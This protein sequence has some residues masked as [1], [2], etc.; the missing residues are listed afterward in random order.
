MVTESVRSTVLSRL[1][2][3]RSMQRVASPAL[4]IGLGSTAC[5]IS[6]HLEDA[7]I[8]WSA[9]DR[10]S[11]GFLYLDTRE[12]TRDEITRSSRFIGLTLPHFSNLR[13]LRPWITECVPELRHLSLSREGALGML[14]NAGVAA[15]YNYASMRGH[16][17][18]LIGE[19]CPYYEGKT[20]LRVHVIAFLGGGTIG[21]LPVLLAAL[22]EARGTA[23]N[24]STVL[25]LLMPQRGMSRDPDN[26]Y[27]LQLRNA[28][29]T[30][31]FLRAATGV[32]AGREQHTGRD[33]YQITV[34]P[35]KTVQAVGP[36][37]D[38]AI[39]HRS[40]K[41]SIPAQK[42]HVARILENLVT[43]AW[44][45]GSDLWAR[46]HET[47]REANNKV[48]AR[49]GSISSKEVSLL[50]GFFTSP[51]RHSFSSMAAAPLRISSN[52]SPNSSPNFMLLEIRERK[53]LS[54]ATVSRIFSAMA[55][56][57]SSSRSLRATRP[58]PKTRAPFSETR[59]VSATSRT[60]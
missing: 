24:F 26:S 50:D 36:H 19:V 39:M 18:S 13:D 53:P 14:A 5:Q 48:D 10:K 31:Q 1:G 17:D 54:M 8:G 37:F 32:A 49:F 30:I 51:T 15:R 4:V 22:S 43:D 44:G 20:Y 27:P 57:R 45:T 7:T 56:A 38:L 59:T 52:N 16:I 33:S 35:D 42:A 28:Y 25:H 23:Y 46:Y 21:A 12:A 41:D 11:L 60:S 9:S 47:M 40:P 58:V 34:Y 3:A 6:Q 2:G 55:K 29:A